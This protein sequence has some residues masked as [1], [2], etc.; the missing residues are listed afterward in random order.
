[1]T[2]DHR[3]NPE[4]RE[5]ATRLPEIISKEDE[6]KIITEMNEIAAAPQLSGEFPVSI[7]E[8][9]AMVV[10]RRVPAHRGK[11]RMVPQEVE[12]ARR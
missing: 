7:E 6:A 11:W 2:S 3:M 5:R 10:K 9:G 4:W 1:L 8:A 12:N